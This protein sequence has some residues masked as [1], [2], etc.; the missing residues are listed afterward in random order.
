RHRVSR[1]VF[2]ESALAGAGFESVWRF[3]APNARLT[4]IPFLL[5]QGTSEALV[6]DREETFLQ[7]L[8]EVF[9]GD[10]TAAPFAD[11]AAYVAA[12]PVR[13]RS[14]AAADYYRSAYTSAEH[15][16]RLLAAG[17]LTIPVLPIAG[18]QSLGSANEAMARN[19]AAN[20]LPGLVLPAVGH[21]V[22]EERPA[23]V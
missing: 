16:I 1:L 14:P 9:T 13:A 17:K 2:I 20:V 15:T 7:H 23:E 21:F 22:P 11:W 19:F 5:M 4:F 18:A 3:D 8:W 10:K 12:P 6:T